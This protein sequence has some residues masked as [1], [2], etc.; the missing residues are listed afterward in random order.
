MSTTGT[1]TLA[2]RV[3][4]KV[5]IHVLG[6][7]PSDPSGELAAKP[8]RE[9]LTIYGNWRARFVSS[10]PRAVHR[11]RELAVSTAA[12]TYAAALAELERKMTAGEDLTP[13]LSERVETAFLSS[14]ELA[15]LPR[16]R[17]EGDRDRMLADWGI[18]HL[19]LSS[20]PGRGG[21]TA[22]G[23]ELLYAVFQPDDAYLLRVYSHA[24]WALE[25]LV[26]VV[27]GNWPDAG[28]FHRLHYATGLTSAWT[29]DDRLKLRKAGVSG[30]LI[31][32][33]GV[34]WG[35]LGQTASGMPFHVARRVMGF[36]AELQLLREDEAG[37]LAGFA[38]ALDRMAGQPVTGEWTPSVDGDSVRLLRGDD[39][40]VEVG[41][42]DFS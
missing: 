6:A 21:F 2:D 17:R 42:L 9:L 30:S 31:E 8:L 24:D 20:A 35:R 41:S 4:E 25:E 22:R 19:H 16:H 13:H 40:G 15:A 12:S 27:V 11:S 36:I 32:I 14:T 39:A 26:R 18:H 33:D 23:P 3:E 37:R 10:R 5:R 28:I 29:D 34:V 38:A 7:M 1:T